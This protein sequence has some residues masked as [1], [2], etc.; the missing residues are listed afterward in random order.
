MSKT[1]FSTPFNYN[2]AKVSNME[3]VSSEIVTVPDQSFTMRELFERYQSGQSLSVHS[4]E[5]RY[6]DDEELDETRSPNFDIIDAYD[7]IG[8]VDLQ[9]KERQRL[10]ELEAKQAKKEYDSMLAEEKEALK[11]ADAE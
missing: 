9:I 3:A 7:A 4:Y 2:P 5:P 8:E 1:R 11:L 10:Q 6:D